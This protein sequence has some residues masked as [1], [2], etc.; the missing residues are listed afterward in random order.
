MT[1]GRINQVTILN[2]TRNRAGHL[3]EGRRSLSLPKGMNT[4]KPYPA[5]GTLP[6]TGEEHPAT[7]SIAPTEFPKG[8]SAARDIAPNGRQTSLH[9]PLE[10]RE[11]AVGHAL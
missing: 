10:W 1:T 2:P 11:L 6:P 9:A 4:A 5:T 3:P 8:R 7:D